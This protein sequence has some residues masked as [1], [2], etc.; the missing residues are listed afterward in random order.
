MDSA[1]RH[2][3]PSVLNAVST[4][5]RGT[6]SPKGITPSRVVTEVLTRRQLQTSLTQTRPI[7]HPLG[8]PLAL[9]RLGGGRG[10]AVKPLRAA[11]RGRE[12]FQVAAA[13][14]ADDFACEEVVFEEG[15]HGGS[16]GFGAAD[17]L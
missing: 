16:H 14:D 7:R 10:G 9:E 15:H 5:S 3:I 8:G 4:D 17:P 13:V 11:E 2:D 1:Q 6:I 12:L